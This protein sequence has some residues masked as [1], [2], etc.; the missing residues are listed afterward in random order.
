MPAIGRAWAAAAPLEAV[1]I[2]SALDATG[3]NAW[4]REHGV[5]PD[6]LHQL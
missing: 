6:E 2:T 1:I 3:Q 4:C 5:Y